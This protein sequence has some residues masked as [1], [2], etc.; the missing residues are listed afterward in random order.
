[1]DSVRFFLRGGVRDAT[2]PEKLDRR[3]MF[4]ETERFFEWKGEDGV[5]GVKEGGW[6]VEE[7]EAICDLGDEDGFYEFDDDKRGGTMVLVGDAA[8]VVCCEFCFA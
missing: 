6:G 8:D 3:G 5:Y 1:L 4:A 7:T 2:V